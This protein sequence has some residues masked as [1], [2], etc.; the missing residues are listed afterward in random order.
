MTSL[1][2]LVRTVCGRPTVSS[3]FGAPFGDAAVTVETHQ[4]L[5]E[6]GQENVVRI[7]GCQYWLNYYSN[8][9]L[10][11]CCRSLRVCLHH[12]CSYMT[13]LYYIVHYVPEYIASNNSLYRRDKTA[14]KCASS[15]LLLC[16]YLSRKSEYH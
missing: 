11:A 9:G 15:F 1:L 8:R 13:K 12:D 5:D 14:E 3:S 6:V 2:A 4:C 10:T 7:H 16:M